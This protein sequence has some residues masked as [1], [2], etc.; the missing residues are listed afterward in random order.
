MKRWKVVFMVDNET[1]ISALIRGEAARCY[2]LGRPTR[3]DPRWQE[4][5]YGLLVF[6]DSDLAINWGKEWAT[7]LDVHAAVLE[8][9][10]EGRM[11]LPR[12]LAVALAGDY[13]YFET[14]LVDSEYRGEWPEGT[15]M[16][17]EVTPVRIIW[18][19]EGC[20]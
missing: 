19:R 11:P 15:E 7:K 14:M 12:I 9:E 5:G 10:A 18:E 16:Y 1:G 17:R 3:A 20:R 2:Q 8:V 13:Q 6:N 4:H